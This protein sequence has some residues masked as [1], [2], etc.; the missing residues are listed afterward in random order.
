MNFSEKL[1]STRDLNLPE[2]VWYVVTVTRKERMNN[3]ALLEQRV[4]AARETSRQDWLGRQIELFK[5]LDHAHKFNKLDRLRIL[6]P[7]EVPFEEQGEL[8]DGSLQ[9]LIYWHS[10]IIW[11]HTGPNKSEI[12]VIPE[13]PLE[14]FDVMTGKEMVNILKGLEEVGTPEDTGKL[15]IKIEGPPDTE[16]G[17]VKQNDI[18]SFLKGGFR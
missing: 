1:L 3:I 2:D 14:M 18:A 8:E 16:S 9:Y 4:K 10:P 11:T 13:I 6:V 15:D 17:L 5:R 7:N 12:Q